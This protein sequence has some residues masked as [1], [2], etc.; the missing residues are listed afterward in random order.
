MTLSQRGQALVEYVLLLA[1]LVTIIIALMSQIKGMLIEKECRSN[2]KSLFCRLF[3][4]MKPGE[5]QMR[6]RYFSVRH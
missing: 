3:I 2:S 6:F 5:E 1:V 4:V